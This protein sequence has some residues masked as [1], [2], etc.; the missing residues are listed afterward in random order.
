MVPVVA[1]KEGESPARDGDVGAPLALRQAPLLPLHQHAVEA[2][3]QETLFEGHSDL[4]A[5][6]QWKHCNKEAIQAFLQ[7]IK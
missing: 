5:G 7:G 6:Q 1:P 3:Q 2:L 4:F